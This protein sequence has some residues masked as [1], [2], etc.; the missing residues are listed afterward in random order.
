MGKW[1][2]NEKDTFGQGYVGSLDIFE[3]FNIL[4]ATYLYIPKYLFPISSNIFKAIPSKKFRWNQ[5]PTSKKN[6]EAVF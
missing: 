4:K 3:T 6:Y 2:K 1:G 5:P